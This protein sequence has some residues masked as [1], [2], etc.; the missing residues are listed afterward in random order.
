MTR[1]RIWKGSRVAQFLLVALLA[2]AGCAEK[3]AAPPEDAGVQD[4]G[5][6]PTPDSSPRPDTHSTT[7]DLA[8]LDIATTPDTRKPGVIR[9][10]EGL[11]KCVKGSPAAGSEV[12]V[13]EG[14]HMKCTFGSGCNTTTAPKLGGTTANASGAFSFKVTVPAVPKSPLSIFAKAPGM[15]C[16]NGYNFVEMLLP[17]NSENL[18][19]TISPFVI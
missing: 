3:S 10:V 5:S 16:G 15:L 12:G 14:Q 8:R 13:Y 6:T 7:Y 17:A 4:Q 11:V 2:G 19:L 1:T 9:V 18:T